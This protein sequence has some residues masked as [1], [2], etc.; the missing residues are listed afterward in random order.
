MSNFNIDGMRNSKHFYI[1]FI[2]IE[3]KEYYQLCI[4]IYFDETANKKIPGDFLLLNNKFENSYILALSSIKN[5]LTINDTINI[6]LES[7]TCDFEKAL[8]NSINKV[9]VNVRIICC[10]FHFVKNYK[11]KYG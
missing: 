9:F 11:I 7:I 2:Y 6:S 5:L 8:L 3:T 1:D 10:L 4:I